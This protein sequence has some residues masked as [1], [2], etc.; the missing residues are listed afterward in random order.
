MSLRK[1]FIIKVQRNNEVFDRLFL[2]KTV[3][4]YATFCHATFGLKKLKLKQL[5]MHAHFFVANKT[6]NFLTLGKI[7][8][9]KY[10][11]AIDP[12]FANLF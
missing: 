7:F 1:I 6:L 9:R 2:V 11:C 5:C 10:I 12:V 3:A 4:F 8:C